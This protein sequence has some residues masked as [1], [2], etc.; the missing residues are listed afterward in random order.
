MTTPLSPFE[1]GLRLM[2][3]QQQL[4]ARSLIN[5]IEMIS[6]TSH[7]YASDTTAFTQEALALMNEAS[8]K[9]DPSALADLQ[10]RW[11]AVCLK[12]GQDQTRAGMSFVEQCGLQALNA[13][14]KD[15]DVK[16]AATQEAPQPDQ[17]SDVAPVSEKAD[18]GKKTTMAATPRDKPKS[19]VRP[20]TSPPKGVLAGTIK[21]KVKT[22]PVATADAARPAKSP[23]PSATK[24]PT[25]VKPKRKAPAKP[26]TA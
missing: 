2:K 3:A 11:T 5:L 22:T 7:R 1:N 21:A 19:A 6:T 12:Y 4:A 16:D 9:R 14:V 26:P 25:S 10:K 13:A 23:A 18:I 24:S 20:E 8:Q 17:A 15:A